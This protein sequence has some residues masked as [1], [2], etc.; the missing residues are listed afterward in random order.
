MLVEKTQSPFGEKPNFSCQPSL[1]PKVKVRHTDFLA[2]HE[3]S[4]GQLWNSDLAFTTLLDTGRGV[5]KG[6]MIVRLEPAE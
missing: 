1:G 3:L 6:E 4:T 2:F 5:P